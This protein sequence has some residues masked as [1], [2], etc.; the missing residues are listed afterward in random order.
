[1]AIGRIPLRTALSVTLLFNK[2]T[3]FEQTV[4]QGLTSR[5]AIFASD[6]PNGYDFEGFSNRLC[7]QLPNSVSCYKINRALPNANALLVGEMNNGRF[8]VNYAGHGN[9]TVWASSG[10]FSS[11]HAGQLTNTNTSIYTMLTCLNGYFINPTDSL[12]EVLLKNQ[13]GGAVSTWS[14]TG[15]TTA[16]IQDVMATRFYGQIG[17]GNFTRIG[18]LIKDAKTTINFGRDVRLSWALLGDPTMKVK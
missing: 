5:G 18:D 8:L 7:Q 10:F 13:N 6:L 17:A 3:T 1:I 2:I 16:D 15:L 12:S 14:S 9:V 11:T 4:T